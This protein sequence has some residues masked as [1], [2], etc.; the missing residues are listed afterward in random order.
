MQPADNR[1]NVSEKNP[2][3]NAALYPHT[4]MPPVLSLAFTLP[5]TVCLQNTHPFVIGRAVV[6]LGDDLLALLLGTS[7]LESLRNGHESRPIIIRHVHLKAHSIITEK[8]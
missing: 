1:T 5:R 3:F 6:E 4:S 7:Q 2:S 8:T